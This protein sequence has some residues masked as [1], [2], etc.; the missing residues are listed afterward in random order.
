M[1]Q[2][3]EDGHLW[4]YIIDNA[5]YRCDCGC[6]VFHKE[7]NKARH[8]IWYICNGCSNVVGELKDE[9]LQET[10]NTGIWK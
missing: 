9:Y 1:K 6:N 8:K 3:H 4:E 5:S 10:L 2:Y 7:Y